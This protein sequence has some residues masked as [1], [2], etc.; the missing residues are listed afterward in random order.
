MGCGDFI[1]VQE[2]L[3]L[4]GLDAQASIMLTQIGNIKLAIPACKC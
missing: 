2:R 1:V 4:P 3:I